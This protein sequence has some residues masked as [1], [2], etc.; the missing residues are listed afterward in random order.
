M[1]VSEI[2]QVDGTRYFVHDNGKTEA[3]PE[4]YGKST[5]QKPVYG[6][7]NASVFYEMDTKK[8]FMLDADTGTWLEQ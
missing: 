6:V 4:Y 7:M 1:S 5:D 8:V 2:V 3:I